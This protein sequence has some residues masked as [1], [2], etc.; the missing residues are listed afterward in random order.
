MKKTSFVLLIL[1]LF[2]P[3][4]A[5]AATVLKP[6]SAWMV[7]PTTIEDGAK[8]DMAGMPCVMTTEFTNDFGLRISGGGEKI[9]AMAVIVGDTPFE[10]DQSYLMTVGFEDEGGEQFPAEAFSADTVVIGVTESADFYKSIKDSDAMYVTL[11]DSQLKFSLKGAAQ[12][13]KRLEECYKPLPKVAAEA[14]AAPPVVA[15]EATGIHRLKDQ[16]IP[17][18]SEVK[19]SDIL[20]QADGNALP[21]MG[22]APVVKGLA[23]ELEVAETAKV[24][25]PVETEELEALVKPPAVEESP[26]PA[27]TPAPV[28]EALPVKEVAPRDILVSAP[29]VKS[30]PEMRWRVS[31]G[32]DLQDVLTEW[33]KGGQVKLVWAADKSFSV[34]ESLSMVATFEEVVQL[35]IAQFPIDKTYPAARFYV[36]PALQQK[37]LVIEDVEAAVKPATEGNYEPIVP[38]N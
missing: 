37:A 24:P 28:T 10:K 21:P 31:K 15:Q 19:A 13:L 4:L 14:V 3:V 33:A 12:G 29:G 2:C 27:P 1:A 36:D 35:L 11:G 34:Q 16:N 9:L 18:Q 20:E 8:A 5:H 23:K 30:A 17:A 26:E 22:D 6:V 32:S 38:P 25:A 7:G